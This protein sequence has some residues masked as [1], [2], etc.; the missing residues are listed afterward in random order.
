LIVHDDGDVELIG[1]IDEPPR[2]L[3]RVAARAA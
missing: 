1:P 3:L 2:M